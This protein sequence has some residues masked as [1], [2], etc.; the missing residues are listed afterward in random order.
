[1]SVHLKSLGDL[2]IQR[3]SSKTTLDFKT[4]EENGYLKKILGIGH[5]V[6]E[7]EMDIQPLF[8]CELM[9]LIIHFS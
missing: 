5:K 6:L 8:V 4:L 7:F 3:Q 9:T 1:M 2:Q